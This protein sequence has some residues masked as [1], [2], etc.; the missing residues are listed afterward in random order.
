MQT[1]FISHIC[2]VQPIHVHEVYMMNDVLSEPSYQHYSVGP[3]SKQCTG[4]HTYTNTHRNETVNVDK[5]K[6]ISYIDTSN[7]IS[8]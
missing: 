6:Y 2:F 7:K 4:A 3:R 1:T 8:V 5:I